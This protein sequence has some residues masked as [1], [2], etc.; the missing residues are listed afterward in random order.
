MKNINK[1][2]SAIIISLIFISFSHSAIKDALFATVGNKAITRSDILNEIKT[3]L[4]LNNKAFSEETREQLETAAVKSIIKRKIKEIEVERYNVEYDN[5]E[6]NY[7]LEKIAEGSLMDLDTLKGTFEAN[8]V[9]FFTVV[10]QVKTDLRWNN[11]IFNLYS[12]RLSINENEI[13]EQLKLFENK[14]ELN[15]FL[16]SEI[17]LSTVAGEKLNDKIKE[18]KNKI[19]TQGFEKVAMDLSIAETAMQ[20]GSLGWVREN[21]I[22]QKY[23]SIITDTPVGEVS[24]HVILPEGILLFKVR[25]KRIAKMQSLEEIKNQLVSAEKTKILNMYSLSHFNNLQRSMT[26][27][28]F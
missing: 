11:L 17:I 7:E 27:N 16:I 18:V 5:L 8:G 13:N 24:K 3:I 25:E 4:I 12:D 10:D 23:K 21:V 2:I 9:D 15:E 22:T 28:Y 14:K 26:I 6:L 19:K 20:G 1:I